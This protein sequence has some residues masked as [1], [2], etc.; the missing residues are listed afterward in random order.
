MK[1]RIGII[2][3][4]NVGTETAN[5]LLRNNIADCVLLDIRNSQ[6]VGKSFDL[7]HSGPLRHA[8]ATITGTD[9]YAALEGCSVVVITAGKPRQPGMTRDDLLSENVQTIRDVC[10]KLNVHVPDAVWIMVTN[11]LD[12]MTYAA[13]KLS[14]KD[15]RT[16]IGMAGALDAARLRATIAAALSVSAIDVHGMVLGSHGDLMIPLAR[17]ATV[18]GIPASELLPPDAMEKILRETVEAGTHLVDLLKTGSAYYAAGTSVASMVDAIVHDS[19]RVI[20]SSVMCKG[21][22]GTDGVCIGVPVLLGA[23][24][25]ERIIELD[26]NDQERSAFMS[27]AHHLKALQDSVDVVLG[28]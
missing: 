6:A 27:A 18:A 26:L 28:A 23:H 22:Y 11:P 20:C 2:G 19:R 1:D 10:G 7:T 9:D 17:Y 25:V 24:G 21:E 5:E 15:R 14:G 12:A 3:A 13:L 4:G 16:V 8:A